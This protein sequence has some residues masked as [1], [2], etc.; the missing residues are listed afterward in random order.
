MI[1]I[2]SKG[3]QHEGSKQEIVSDLVNLLY[4]FQDIVKLD[5]NELDRLEKCLVP[6][7]RQKDIKDLTNKFNLEQREEII[8]KLYSD[9]GI[10]H[11]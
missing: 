1:I 6:M 7:L 2:D 9:L 11:L 3:I 4:S 8:L 5:K 10:K